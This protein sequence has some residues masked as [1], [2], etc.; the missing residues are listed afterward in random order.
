MI[1]ALSKDTWP[2]VLTQSGI[3]PYELGAVSRTCRPLRAMIAENRIQFWNLIFLREGLRPMQEE[4]TSEFLRRS[5]TLCKQLASLPPYLLFLIRRAA[6]LGHENLLLKTAERLEQSNRHDKMEYMQHVFKEA[7]G[8]GLVQVVREMKAQMNQ[9][10]AGVA[11]LRAVSNNHLACVKELV[12]WKIA[13]WHLSDAIGIAFEKKH[14]EI[15]E[16][17]NPL[18][19]NIP[20]VRDEPGSEFLIRCLERNNCEDLE[21]TLFSLKKTG[22][23][24]YNLDSLSIA[25]AA[26]TVLPFRHPHLDIIELL[27]SY[28]EIVSELIKQPFFYQHMRWRII[29]ISVH[30]QCADVF[31]AI[32]LNDDIRTELSRTK[33]PYVETN[34]LDHMIAAQGSLASQILKLL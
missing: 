18:V 34:T 28:P 10:Y 29:A 6:R 1:G 19:E 21:L 11:L 32:L 24:P 26:F 14:T 9:G 16:V 12:G 22:F 27:L 15:L 17:L 2:C 23:L 31:A 20:M 7:A 5:W 13:E 33:A 8:A 25:R 30:P 3:T 4:P